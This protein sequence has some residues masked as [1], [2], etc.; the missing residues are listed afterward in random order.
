MVRSGVGSGA[1]PA[2]RE[3]GSF[4]RQPAPRG[5]D[6]EHVNAYTNSDSET[7]PCHR[8]PVGEPAGAACR[9]SDRARHSPP[10]GDDYEVLEWY[11]GQAACPGDRSPCYQGGVAHVLEVFAMDLKEQICTDVHEGRL[12]VTGDLAQ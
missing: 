4:G 3:P 5:K 1:W 7:A 9:T 6:D 8:P 2:V 11:A 12:L 10:W